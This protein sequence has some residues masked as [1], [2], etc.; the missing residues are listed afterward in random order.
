MVGA[1]DWSILRLEPSSFINPELAASESDLLFQ[2]RL[3]GTDS[4][5]YLLFEHQ[6]SQDPRVGPG[7][8]SYILRI[9]SRFEM[10]HPAQSK[11]PAVFSLVLAQGKKPWR[12]PPRIEALIDLPEPVA[13][14]LLPWQSSLDYS[15][16]EL[17][18]VPYPELRGTPE[19]IL[20][21]R[22]LKAQPV[23]ELFTDVGWDEGLLF[24]VS[25]AALERIIRYI[26]SPWNPMWTGFGSTSRGFTAKNH[27]APPI[28]PST[29][30]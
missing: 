15:V 12:Q 29:T 8:L 6:S 11:F 19:G 23:G 3:A 24:S 18:R 14:L 4:S 5:I 2:V 20:T 21:L 16:L 25:D 26:L 17:V 27:S 13:E 10:N 30:A 1:L 28:W 22:A 9:W 7:L